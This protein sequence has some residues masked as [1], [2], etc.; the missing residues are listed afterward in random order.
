MT[1][2]LGRRGARAL[3]AFGA[4]GLIVTCALVLSLVLVLGPLVEE[5]GAFERQRSAAIAALA[6]A[7]TVLDTTAASADGASAS[8]ADAEA[9]LRDASAVTSQLADAA[10]GLAAFSGA[11]GD[12]ATRSRALS[13]ELSRT[14][15]AVARSGD[16]SRALAGQVRILAGQVQELSASLGPAEPGVGGLLGTS[17]IPLLAALVVAL[18]TWLGVAAGTCLWLGRQALR[19]EPA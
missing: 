19:G 11:F 13:D 8:L 4:S 9:T 6:S 12:T 1:G 2:R 15:D 14:A 5:A 18:L 16:D 17:G 3:V 10:A 7:S